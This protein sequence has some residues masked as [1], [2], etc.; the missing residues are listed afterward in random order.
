MPVLCDLRSMSRSVMYLQHSRN[1]FFGRQAFLR[2]LRPIV[3]DNPSLQLSFL[4]VFKFLDFVLVCNING[5]DS[6][7]TLS[8]AGGLAPSFPSLSCL[9]MNV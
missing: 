6:P 8:R 3:H 2:I 9:R 4:R 1:A 5:P 7:S